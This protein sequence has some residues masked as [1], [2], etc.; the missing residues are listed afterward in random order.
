MAFL[1]VNL[2]KF[3]R[4]VG[5]GCLIWLAI[6]LILYFVQPFRIVNFWC[7]IWNGSIYRGVGYLYNVFFAG[8]IRNCCRCLNYNLISRTF[9]ISRIFLSSRTRTG[10]CFLL[11]CFLYSSLFDSCCMMGGW[12][13]FYRVNK[14]FKLLYVNTSIC[15]KSLRCLACSCCRCCSFF[16]LNSNWIQLMF[17]FSF[18]Q[19]SFE[20]SFEVFNFSLVRLLMLESLII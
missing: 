1:V 9:V 17:L 10:G 4:V 7:L 13:F 5:Y 20:L 15:I 2:V 8:L 3:F 11:R 18:C 6:F 14:I 12:V 19:L 16:T